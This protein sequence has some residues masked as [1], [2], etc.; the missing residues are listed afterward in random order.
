M[1]R[2]SAAG[3]NLSDLG[4]EVSDALR[5]KGHPLANDL[6]CQTWKETWKSF[7]HLLASILQLRAGPQ[8]EKRF[9]QSL[10]TN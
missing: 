8:E 1:Y 5:V 7:F 2:A 6:K 10:K 4:W 3:W 9:N